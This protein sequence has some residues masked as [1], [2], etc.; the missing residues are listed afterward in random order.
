MRCL[1]NVLIGLFFVGVL[2]CGNEDRNLETIEFIKKPES[3]DDL[4]FF[5]SSNKLIGVNSEK[6]EIEAKVKFNTNIGSAFSIGGKLFVSDIGKQAGS[7]GDEVFVLFEGREPVTK[8]ETLPNPYKIRSL[9]DFTFVDCG[10]YFKNGH[11]GFR[12]YDENFSMVYENK[13][14]KNWVVNDGNWI[15]NGFAYIGIEPNFSLNS[16]GHIIRLNLKTFETEIVEDFNQPHSNNSFS[17]VIH[18]NLLF[19]VFRNLYRINVF[20]LDKQ[21]RVATLDL[22]EEFDFLQNDPRLFDDS[23]NRTSTYW[24]YRPKMYNGKLILL[25]LDN[26]ADVQVQK[27]VTIDPEE[28]KVEKV[29]DLEDTY[30]L[31]SA[32]IKDIRNGKV[33]FQQMGQVLVF[34]EETGE[35]LKTF[36]L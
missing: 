2:A 5:A 23:F 25:V 29:V 31:G 32:D 30:D 33:F 3:F 22:R 4:L 21:E 10:G 27:L 28:F 1:L 36:E 9:G 7:F 16:R 26:Y 15:Y 12:L 11:T 35:H 20:N 17:L 34:S 13:K 18:N 19:T 14:L 8:I 24:I 6:L